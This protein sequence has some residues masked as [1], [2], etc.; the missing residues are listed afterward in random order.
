M[1]SSTTSFWF[2][3]LSQT[4]NPNIQLP[5]KQLLVER[6]NSSSSRTI[7]SYQN[8][9]KPQDTRSSWKK[10][11]TNLL[12]HLYHDKWCTDS[13]QQVTQDRNLE[14]SKMS[15][16]YMCLTTMTGHTMSTIYLLSHPQIHPLL[17][18]FW[19]VALLVSRPGDAAKENS[20]PQP[21]LQQ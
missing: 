6:L 14:S 15:P 17:I 8:H 3:P 20:Y 9:K 7:N 2:R 10:Q 19:D 12:F 5:I 11:N 13:I 18:R 4:L 1:W 21:K 16:L